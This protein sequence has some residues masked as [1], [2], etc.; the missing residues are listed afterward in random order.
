MEDYYYYFFIT[1]AF[2]HRHSEGIFDIFERILKKKNV[3]GIHRIISRKIPEEISGKTLR[4]ILGMTPEG[5][6][7]T[8]PEEILEVKPGG[9]L[10]CF[11][12]RNL[13][14]MV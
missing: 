3:V 6:M 14:E 10:E 7:R 8:Y 2:S 1:E 13:R 4:G 12:V 9:I 5:I 11:S